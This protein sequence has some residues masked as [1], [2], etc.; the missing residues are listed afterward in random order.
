MRYQSKPCASDFEKT[1]EAGSIDSTNA[2]YVGRGLE[3]VNEIEAHR[4]L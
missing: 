2:D 4:I 3:M 1:H